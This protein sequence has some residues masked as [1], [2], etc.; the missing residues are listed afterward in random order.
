MEPL[1]IAIL[2]AESTG[3]TAL[4]QALAARIQIET[5]LACTWVSEWLRLWCA[6]RGRTP[7]ADEQAAIAAEQQR[8]VAAAC[9]GHAVVLADTSALMTAVYS[10]FIFGDRTLNAAALQAQR[11]FDL[12]LLTALDLPWQADG[13]QRDGAPVREPVDALLRGHLLAARLPWALVSGSGAKRLESALDALAP[14]LR[15]RCADAPKQG[16]FSRLAQRD[17][18]APEWR[19]ECDCDVPAC[20]H[21]GLRRAY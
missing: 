18:A 4:A 6:Q 17:A 12:S 20:E 14:L 10:E 5:G 1:R 15:T 9:I 8:R 21:A 7:R 13:L 2:G 11:G 3:K 19:W 16:L